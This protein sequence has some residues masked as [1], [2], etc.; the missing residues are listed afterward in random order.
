MPY[1]VIIVVVGFYKMRHPWFRQRLPSM[2]LNFFLRLPSKID[3]MLCRKLSKISSISSV[4]VDSLHPSSIS[5]K[6]HFSSLRISSSSSSP[7]FCIFPFLY[8][9]KISG[10]HLQTKSYHGQS[11]GTVDP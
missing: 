8:F 9:S 7:L 10:L 2:P 11:V 3:N 1:Q 6:T 4:V 5:K